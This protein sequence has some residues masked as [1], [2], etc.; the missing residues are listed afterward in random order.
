MLSQYPLSP[1]PSRSK[2]SPAKD[3][4][5]TDTPPHMVASFGRQEGQGLGELEEDCAKPCSIFLMM[6]LMQY[7]KNSRFC[8]S[9]FAFDYPLSCLTSELEYEISWQ[10]RVLRTRAALHSGF[11]VGYSP[12]ECKMDYE[13]YVRRLGASGMVDVLN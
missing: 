3:R 2:Q 8:C 13:A 10:P 11:P 1:P 5:H 4:H 9:T 7:C 12:R 6:G